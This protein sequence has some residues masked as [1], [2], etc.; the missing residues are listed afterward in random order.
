MADR[1]SGEDLARW[2][3]RGI[4]EDALAFLGTW[5]G[6]QLAAEFRETMAM[7]DRATAA[8]AAAATDPATDPARAG[9]GTDLDPHAMLWAIRFQHRVLQMANMAAHAAPFVVFWLSHAAK[10]SVS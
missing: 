9:D 1:L 8:A 10:D 7:A 3:N 5:F 6:P 4:D 2:R